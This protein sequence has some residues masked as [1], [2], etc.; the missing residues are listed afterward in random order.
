[1]AEMTGMAIRII[2]FLIGLIFLVVILTIGIQQQLRG[3]IAVSLSG[4]V[5]IVGSVWMG[6]WKAYQC[7]YTVPDQISVVGHVKDKLSSSYL[8]NYLVILYRGD[9]EIGRFVTEKG[10]FQE[11][12]K[13]TEND[14]YFEFDI[15]NTDRLTRCS[16]AVDFRQDSSGRTFLGLG[17]KTTYLWHD[18]TDV[19]AG[20]YLPINIGDSK[21]YT[22]VVLPGIKDNLPEE[23]S[24]YHTY[25]NRNG[26]AAINAPVKTYAEETTSAKA[27]PTNFYAH[28]SQPLDVS[29]GGTAVRNAWVEAT[30]TAAEYKGSDIADNDVIDINHCKDQA[31]PTKQETR[32]LAF[33]R[34]VQFRPAGNQNYDLG[35][36]ALKAVPSLGFTQGEMTPYDAKVDIDVPPGEHWVYKITWH[37][38]WRPGKIRVDSGQQ[39]DELSFRESYINGWDVW[40]EKVACPQ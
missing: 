5:L 25:L 39:M 9:E 38:Y 18:F 29:S 10:K 32:K 7:R 34:E 11:D 27:N 19:E 35:M 2:L 30:G 31:S 15:P 26:V 4:L 37:A 36:V 24:Q 33:M 28:L 14:G 22:L 40:V 13:D 20:T 1:M 21:K 6:N 16:M 3:W 8:N 12:K 17:N 23:I